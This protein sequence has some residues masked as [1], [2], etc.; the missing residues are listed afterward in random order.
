MTSRSADVAAS[1][2]PAFV[3]PGRKRA[4]GDVIV[5]PPSG[6]AGHGH[7]RGG[8][9]ARALGTRFGAFADCQ[10]QFLG[11]LRTRLETLDAAI[12]EDARARLKGA[13]RGALDVLDWCDAVQVDLANESGW[14]AAG[15]EPLDL[16]AL[17]RDVAAEVDPH[18]GEVRV[19]GQLPQPW[20]GDAAAVAEAVRRGLRLVSE[21][22]GGTGFRE[23][24]IGTDAQAPWVRIA[25]YGEPGDG[26]EADT[27][28]AF[29][30][31]AGQLA[32]R[33]TP[34]PLGPGGA[35]LVLHLP[36]RRA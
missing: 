29:R 35:A 13:L 33:V 4:G 14:A 16:V 27:V 3:L 24:E 19:T 6:G 34:D 7:E 26:V 2:S 31:A 15:L 18:V 5:V 10:Q 36:D 25:G 20:W 32:A 8:H 23:V 30:Q 1:L 11:E 22:I 21:R 28:A 9:V 12:A 17:C